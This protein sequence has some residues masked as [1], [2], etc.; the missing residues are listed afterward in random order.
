MTSR[1]SKVRYQRRGERA[2]PI[3]LTER[4]IEVL[5]E[6]A[7][8]RFLSGEQ[9]RR[10]VFDCGTSRVRRRLRALFDHG[11]VERLPVVSPPAL[12]LPP[13]VYVVTKEAKSLLEEQGI[14]C[15]ASDSQRPGLCLVRH[16]YLVN[17][18]FVTLTEACRLGG[19]RIRQWQHEQ[20]LQLSGPDG[21]NC[22]MQVDHP[23]P[24]DPAPLLPDAY[25]ELEVDPRSTIAFFLEM[26][27]G[28][29]VQRIWRDRA[30]QYAAYADTAAGLFR[31][32][33]GREAF[34]LLVVTPR[35]WRQR[36]RC[37][38]ILS[39]IHAAVGDSDLFLGVP[40]SDVT[41][42]RILGPI[43]RQPGTQERCSL[44]SNSGS[45]VKLRVRP[46]Q[47]RV[48]DHVG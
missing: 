24:R 16:R 10:L 28:T 18:F 15:P 26:D 31:Q 35:D 43:W 2:K 48:A 7:F 1:G 4:D 8:H 40:M 22:A 37:D 21:R 42:E 38:N 25:F 9:L 45:P 6:L 33:F 29:H 47:S 13:F 19:C 41:P 30:R 20:Q 3:C 23:W 46:A 17:E 44:L 12:G 27:L 11:L 14:V 32:R 39:T 34:R 5:R 36:S